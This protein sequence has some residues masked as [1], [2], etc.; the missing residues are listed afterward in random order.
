MLKIN[1]ELCVL[2]QECV[3]VCPF[4]A[5]S[6]DGKRIVVSESCRLCRVCIK[7]CP[8]NA[9][10][11]EQTKEEEQTPFDAK[12]ILVV[13]EFDHQGLH[14]VTYE[15]I[16]K[17]REMADSIDQ[18]LGCVLVGKGCSRV[19][20]GLLDYGVDTCFVYDHEAFEHFRVEPY[21]NALED[22]IRKFNPTIVLFAATPA[23]RS[24]APRIA[25]RFRTGL[26]ADCTTLEVRSNGELVQIR[27]AFGGNIMAQIVTPK[28]RPQMATMRYKIMEPARPRRVPGARVEIRTL[29]P[30]LLL[31]KIS[32]LHSE[33]KPPEKSITD[34]DVIIAAGRGIKERSNLLMLEE[35]AELLGGQVGVT[36]PLVEAGW[37]DQTRQIGLSGRAV[38]PKLLITVGVSGAVQFTASITG[39]EVIAAINNDP[40]APIFQVAHYGLVGDLNEI[41][42]A[43]IREL[44]GV[45]EHAV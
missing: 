24:L 39:A 19:G 45:S 17:G 26:T 41:V 6:F 16:G 29:K 3:E 32:V 28:H 37:A 43:L 22:V 34:A 42:P 23:G 9:I 38:R 36:R 1:D 2:C 18:P 14:P 21:A 30:E 44:G 12:G 10:Y 33:K 20:S 31:S 15:L 27:P 35:L 13:A 11:L 40:Q 7:K 8:E 4:G 25:A 5:L